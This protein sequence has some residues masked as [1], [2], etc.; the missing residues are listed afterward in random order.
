MAGGRVGAVHETNPPL[1]VTV[2]VS[3]HAVKYTDVD[4]YVVCSSHTTPH[5]G[6]ITTSAVE[7]LYKG[8]SEY[9]IPL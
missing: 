7:P 2:N 6:G 8:H 5:L 3:S 1:L 9:G 4:I